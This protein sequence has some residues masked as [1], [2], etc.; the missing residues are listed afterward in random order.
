M[1]LSLSQLQQDRDEETTSAA[2]LRAIP[3]R[4]PRAKQLLRVD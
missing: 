3:E 4:N 2:E 1:T